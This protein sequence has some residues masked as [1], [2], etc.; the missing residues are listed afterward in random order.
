MNKYTKYFILSVCSIYIF[1]I[2]IFSNKTIYAQ[3]TNDMSYQYLYN[4]LTNDLVIVYEDYSKIFVDSTTPIDEEFFKNLANK[5]EIWEAQFE[6]SKII[7]TRYSNNQDANVAEIAKI[8]LQSDVT[9]LEAIK[10]YKSMYT[11]PDNAAQYIEQGDIKW[12]NAI[13]LHDQAVDLYNNYSGA[14]TAKTEKYIYIWG[15]V[16]FAIISLALLIKSFTRSQSSV[17]KLRAKIF[18]NLFVTSLWPTVGFAVT[19]LL[20]L[21]ATKDGSTYYILYGPM[22]IGGWQLIKGISNYFRH[23]RPLLAEAINSELKQKVLDEYDR[24]TDQSKVS[25]IV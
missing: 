18:K 3:E 17:K 10:S 15:T 12:E 19:T 5:L 22:A 20:Y 9:G 1:L 4:A 24:A 23:D 14:N 2:S 21:A 13:T 7:F 8:G 6:K 11:D 25:Q 16:I